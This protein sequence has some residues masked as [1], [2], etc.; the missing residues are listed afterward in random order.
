[1]GPNFFNDIKLFQTKSKNIHFIAIG[2][3][4]ELNYYWS[5]ILEQ[6]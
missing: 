1:M 3:F 6:F 2:V 5:F 4:P